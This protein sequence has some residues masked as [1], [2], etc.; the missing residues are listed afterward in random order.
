M[1]ALFGQNAPEVFAL[2]ALQFMQFN[3]AK[4]ASALDDSGITA[5]QQSIVAFLVKRKSFL[6]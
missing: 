4:E 1:R 6:V 3:K 2:C 5:L